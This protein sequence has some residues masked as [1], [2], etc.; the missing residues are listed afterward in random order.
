MNTSELRTEITALKEKENAI[1]LA[2]YYQL[3]EVQEIADYTGDS[4]GLSEQAASTEADV[5][6]FCGVKFMAESACILSPQ[7]TVLLPEQEAGCPLA[8]EISPEDLVAL[9]KNYPEAAVVCY[10]NSSAEIK[11]LSDICCTSSNA[12]DVVNS[13]DEKQVLFVPDRN[14]ASY[15]A[16]YTDKE[17]IA[18]D[19]CCPT[20]DAMT[21][22]DV[23]RIRKTHPGCVVTVHPECRPEVTALA[24]H[25]GST[26]GIIKYARETPAKK[27]VIG[28]EKG[29]LYQLKKENPGKEFYLLS[30]K[31]VCPTMKVISLEKLRN[32]LKNKMHRVTVV[33][34]VIEKANLALNRMLEVTRQ[35]SGKLG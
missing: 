29:T 31:L 3:D 28:T 6:V 35:G 5:I 17:I 2:H 16:G 20:H 30:D 7:K 15:V 25:V 33:E 11:A 18:W 10:V 21:A 23:Y 19:G 12:I 22:D 14:L 32:A 8:D 9:K 24:D 27:I 34:S 13:L 26:A 1:I 4:F